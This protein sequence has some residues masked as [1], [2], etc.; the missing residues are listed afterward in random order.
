M[1]NVFLISTLAQVDLAR[2]VTPLHRTGAL[3]I[4]TEISVKNFRQMVLLFF[5]APKTGTWLSCI[6]H[7]I[8]VNFS[9]SLDMK[10]GNSNPN[11]W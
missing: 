10:P 1:V 2:R 7:K 4:C 5:F 8:T 9:L 3:T 11:K 6:I